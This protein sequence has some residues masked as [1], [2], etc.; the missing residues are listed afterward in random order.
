MACLVNSSAQLNPQK[1][2]STEIA[3][4]KY[5]LKMNVDYSA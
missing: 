1:G 5:F 3:F 4:L 2:S